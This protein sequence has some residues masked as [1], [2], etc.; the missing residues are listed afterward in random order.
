MLIRDLGSRN[1]LRVNGRIVEEA[2]LNPGDEVAIGPVL[3]R[4]DFEAEADDTAGA[5]AALAA[6]G[7][8]PPASGI[9]AGRTPST[10]RPGGSSEGNSEEDLVPLDDI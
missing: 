5:P 10:R 2:R 9:V 7:S 4:V 1:G 8:R 3:Y 6:P